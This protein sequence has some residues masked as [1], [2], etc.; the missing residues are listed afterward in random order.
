MLVYVIPNI[1]TYAI[2]M[3]AIAFIV[4]FM[5]H[6]KKENVPMKTLILS[7]ISV[8]VSAIIGRKSYV[9]NREYRKCYC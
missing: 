7:V 6:M 8:V 9:G 2:I 3:A 4:Y 5:Y 1:Y